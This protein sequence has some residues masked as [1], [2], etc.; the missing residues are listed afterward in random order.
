MVHI[1]RIDEMS[2]VS[3]TL[4]PDRQA[5]MDALQCFSVPARELVMMI[6]DSEKPIDR[7]LLRKYLA[8]LSSLAR[9]LSEVEEN[10]LNI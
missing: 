1:R 7:G 8:T 6:E 9:K 3:D 4:P 5:V 2:G 10:V